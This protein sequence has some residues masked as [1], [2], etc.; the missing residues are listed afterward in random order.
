MLRQM[1]MNIVRTADSA[2]DIMQDAYLKLADHRRPGGVQ[3]PLSYCCQVVRNLAMD[4]FRRRGTEA[5]YRSFGV[6]VETLER[7]CGATPDRVLHQKRVLASIAELLTELPDR[8]RRAFELHRLQEM[9][10]REI[11]ACLNCS[12][13]LVNFMIRD[14]AEALQS[15]REQLDD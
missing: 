11:A 14:A 8:T 2:D 3:K 7:S 4:H 15:C 1:A 12:A 13:T 5:R 9:T 10:Q 6:D